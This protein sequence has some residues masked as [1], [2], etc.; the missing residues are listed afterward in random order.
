[1]MELRH[2]GLQAEHIVT[3]AQYQSNLVQLEDLMNQNKLHV[4]RATVY[5]AGQGSIVSDLLAPEAEHVEPRICVLCNVVNDSDDA[6]VREI[7]SRDILAKEAMIEVN[8]AVVVADVAPL[9]PGHTLI[10]SRHHV[11][12]MSHLASYQIQEVRALLLRVGNVLRQAYGKSV[13]AFEHGLCDPSVS[14]ECSVDHA[15]LH[16]LPFDGPLASRF[17]QTFQV[18]ALD[19]L[20]DL[21]DAITSREEYLLLIDG[22][23]RCLL[24]FPSGPT[25]QYFRRAISEATGQPMWNWNDRL[26]LANHSE[27][28][29]WILHLHRL[30]RN[31]GNPSAF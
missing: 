11:L 7:L 24:A 9:V 29:E 12:S 17:S 28:R 4:H 23:G 19:S 2:A 14:G 30:F 10:M 20:T 21:P 27:A 6:P 3:L 5:A 1:M 25:R 26:L 31:G 22:E 18:T 15:H 16:V 8:D 13:I